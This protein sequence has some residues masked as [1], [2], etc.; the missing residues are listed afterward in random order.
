M[1]EF[2]LTAGDSFKGDWIVSDVAWD[3][4]TL[5][6]DLSYEYLRPFHFSYVRPSITGHKWACYE[7]YSTMDEDHAHE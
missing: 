4:I 6:T 7:R 1:S 2:I 5:V 3:E